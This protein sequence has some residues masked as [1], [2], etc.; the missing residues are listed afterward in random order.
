[1]PIVVVGPESWPSVGMLREAVGRL[2]PT[3]A[4]MVV[5]WGV[6]RPGAVNGMPRLNAIEQ[7]TALKSAGVLCPEFTTDVEIAKSWVR[8]GNQVYGRHLRHSQGTDIIG[9]GYRPGGHR[10]ITTRK[11]NRVLRG[12]IAERWNRKW[13]AREWW[14]KVIPNVAE[15]WRIHAMKSQRSGEYRVIARAKK[16]Q[17]SDPTRRMLV[18]SR[19][20]GWTMVHNVEP[21]D[22]VREAG[23][24]A[25]RACEYDFGGVDVFV[26][27][28]GD[29]GVF[30]VNSACG[31]D[32]Y[33]ATQYAN[34]ISKYCVG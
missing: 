30:E 32:N 11:G 26:L 6:Q 13:L 7:L 20:N 21:S 16:V 3:E 9:A 25:V 27:T 15:E 10:Y 28:S 29:V 1:M 24:S 8:E 31:L 2:P 5:S 23:K 33:T 12:S 14:S 19:R 4:E 18:R 34:A 17:T 22:A